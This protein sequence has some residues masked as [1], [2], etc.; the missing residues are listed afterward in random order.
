[1]K[2]APLKSSFMLIS[3]LGFM[4]SV[5]YTSYGTINETWGF[6]FGLVF[7]MMFVASLI[8]MTNA[9]YEEQL[10]MAEDFSIHHYTAKHRQE[11]KLQVSGQV[12]K[13]A[14]KTRR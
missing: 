3:M 1:M 6:T 2:V 8:S 5:V 10:K 14:H 9:P 7:A 12:S 11:P 13:V 4:V